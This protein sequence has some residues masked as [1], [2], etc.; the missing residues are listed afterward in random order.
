MRPRYWRH[1]PRWRLIYHRV[2]EGGTTVEK[3]W[4]AEAAPRTRPSGAAVR[5]A[6]GYWATE[7]DSDDKTPIAVWLRYGALGG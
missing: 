3:R 4:N 5:S 1:D 2:E 6:D 7:Y